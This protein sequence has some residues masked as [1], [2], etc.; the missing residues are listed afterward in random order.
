[1][2]VVKD[3]QHGLLLN[4]FGL[5][6]KYYLS[7]TVLT[8]F[9]FSDPDAPLSEQDLWPFVQSELGKDA[10]LD[11]AMPKLKGEVLV[12]GRCFTPGGAPRI[13]GEVGFHAGAIEKTLHV[14]GDRFWQKAGGTAQVITDPRP[15][16]EMPIT[17][18]RAFGGSGFE[19]NPLG[20]GA[21]PVLSPEGQEIRPLPNIEIPGRLIGA[22]SDRPIPAGFAPIDFTWPQRTKKVG[23]YDE[24]W[25]QER[26]PFYPDDMD[27][28]YFNAAPEDQQMDRYFQAGEPIAVRNMHPEKPLLM[29]AVPALRQRCFL[30]Q[31]EDM[32]RKDGE[33]IFKEINTHIDTLWLFPHAE[34]GI[35]VFRGSTV[36][37][38]DE[39]LDVDHLFIATELSADPPKDIQH[40]HEVFLKRLDRGVG[41]KIAGAMEK[42][43]EK[44]SA[45]ADRLK[46]LPLEISD[47]VA[48]NLGDAPRPVRTPHEVINNALT[49]IDK[50]QQRLDGA[51]KKI[52]ALK[53]KHGHRMKIDTSPFSSARQQFADAKTR[54]TGLAT[55][56]DDVTAKQAD[57]FSKLRPQIGQAVAGIDPALL[58]DAGFDPDT[59]FAAFAGT[60]DPWQ[61][62]GMRFIEPCRDAL[63]RRPHL[64]SAFRSLGFRPY[65]LKRAWIGINP[66]LKTFQR[67][68]WG[69][70]PNA[71]STPDPSVLI[72]PPGL[73][74]P[75]F[76]GARIVRITI[77]PIPADTGESPDMA[78]LTRAIVN[79]DN[80]VIVEG[81]EAAAM[82]ISP[83]DKAF[84]RVPE[85]LD[86]LFLHQEIGD[87]AAVIA[88]KTPDATPGKTAEALLKTTPQFI[89]AC[90]A[91]AT[92]EDVAAAWQPVCP[93]AEALA[94]PKEKTLFA[95][96][97]EG[98][99]LWQ[100]VADALHPEHAPDLADKPKEVDVTEPGALAALV[101]VI[102]VAGI[103]G[104]V[105]NRLTAKMQAGRDALEKS[106]KEMMAGS[107]KL[108][109]DRGIAPES[110]FA[111]AK[112]SETPAANPYNA[113]KEK[114]TQKFAA[115]KNTLAEHNAL[116][117]DVEKTLAEVEKKN[118]GILTNAARQYD[119]GKAKLAAVK[120][121]AAAGPP[122][123]AR[124]L[125]IDA[126]LDPDDP[127]PLKPLDREAVVQRL[128]DGGR[129]AGKNLAGADLSGLDFRGID[130]RRTQ[131]QKTN[132]TGC[133][134][135]GAD[136][137][138]AIA[139]EADFS[140]ASLRQT[141]MSKGL[142]QKAVFKEAR[143]S[144][145][146][147]TQAIM[148]EADLTGADLTGAVL[149]KTLLE[150]AKLI[151]ARLTDA[152]AGKG[153]F[154]ST[155]VSQ[156]DFSG[157]DV[158]KAVFLKANIDQVDFSRSTARGTIFIE[159]TGDKVNFAGADM[160]NSR[161]LN[162]SAMTRSDFTRANAERACW[163]KS[164]LSQSDFRG[165]Q[166][167][168]GLVQEC[169]LSAS[170]LSGISAK[171]ARLT[172]TDLSDAN[173]KGINLMTGS[174]RKS[175]LVRT[176][177]SGANLYGAEF[178]RTGVGETRFDE[179]NLKMTKLYKRTDLIA[180]IE[181]E[182]K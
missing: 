148:S 43:H 95:A 164:D 163:M 25:L 180:E 59:F 5:A 64:M 138:G 21:A 113:A 112:K 169:D 162:G 86:A 13:A 54:L 32:A 56:V 89:V 146:D 114:F 12:W 65:T 16:T 157:A 116:T 101:P 70:K 143:M 58:K 106:K 80:D 149:T 104:Q 38:D 74:I 48:R 57:T 28:T 92:G 171:Q 153:Y 41:T 177:L 84:I 129:L 161:I 1:M 4:H 69:L 79:T 63:K 18:Q 88:M 68:A 34:R 29:S 182:K 130:L 151:G 91:T 172:K 15:F 105:R 6:D 123:W 30:N 178:Y 125:M 52:L 50:G 102:D 165:A 154:L 100:W 76:D 78:R 53:A 135:D 119:E 67:D 2:K 99:D 81:S 152:K 55:T 82:V 17:W 121:A 31:C 3:L 144:G 107:G 62:S 174:L 73:V 33:R 167:K 36:V 35:A 14:F 131:F 23:T 109:R 60:T 132:L 136:L 145:S 176:D 27:W 26:W 90:E 142:F 170:D 103:I 61:D 11:A 87:M 147:L 155:D 75:C 108:L 72:I 10:I 94:L 39:A 40:Y 150:K 137:S 111:A 128:A 96:K 158:T 46:D 133:N 98:V 124:K 37:A 24:R 115:M 42:A 159:S 127:A 179:A 93:A 22:P 141:V 140:K 9:A 85:E 156:A 122:D 45:A 168:R 97:K 71:A 83:G 20:R 44:L 7:L 47:A 51:E 181:K 19:Q 8:F 120:A 173:L 110:V 118:M 160:H 77:R 134:L 166:L 117:P 66:E 139:N 126:G 49:T 175:K